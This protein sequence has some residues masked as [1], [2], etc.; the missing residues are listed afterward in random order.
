[1]AIG[2][3]ELTFLEAFSCFNRQ[4]PDLYAFS[5]AALVLYDPS[6]LPPSCSRSSARS[7]L[8]RTTT[9]CRLSLFLKVSM[10]W[11]QYSPSECEGHKAELLVP[12]FFFPGF[13]FGRPVIHQSGS[14]SVH[15]FLPP[16]FSM[17]CSSEMCFY[18]SELTPKPGCRRS[19]GAGIAKVDAEKPSSLPVLTDGMLHLPGA[20]IFETQNEITDF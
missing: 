18:F 5:F 15:Y 10:H 1:M 2:T 20:S 17:V 14:S 11:M 8:L 4:M 6:P 9:F 7:S 12:F 16:V 13:S 19:H 3:L